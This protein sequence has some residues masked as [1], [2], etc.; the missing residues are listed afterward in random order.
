MKAPHLEVLLP[1]LAA[2]AVVVLITAPLGWR[3]MGRACVFG[4]VVLAVEVVVISAAPGVGTWL[5]GVAR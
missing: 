3:W 4:L 1:M 5:A 2:V